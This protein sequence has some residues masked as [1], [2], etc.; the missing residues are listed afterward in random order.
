MAENPTMEVRARLTA[1]SAQFVQGM[2]NATAAA[3][4]FTNTSNMVNSAMRGF[5]VAAAAGM[6]GL[7]ALGTQSFMAAAR[8]Q[9]LDIAIN[10]V[11]KS[12]GLGYDAI[13]NA[14]IGIK[15]MGIEMAVAQR[16]AL[17]FAQ[18]NLKLADA[19]KLARTAQDLAV[20]SGKNSTEE[21]Q[22]LTYAV[23]TQR[24]EL[25]KSAGVNGSV[26]QAYDKM[27]KSLGIS[28][29][30]LTAGQK[31]QAAMN[32][33]LEEGAK[34]AGTYEAAMTSPGKVLRSFARLND[35]LLVAVGNALLKGIGPM[36]VAFYHFEK[37]IV[38]VME[39]TGAFHAIITALTAVMV[40]IFT[41]ITNFIEGLSSIVEK[42]DKAK[43]NVEGLAQKLNQ[44]LPILLAVGAG[45]AAVGGAALFE[46]VPVLGKV[47][48]LVAGGGGLPVALI[49]LAITSQ[50]VRDGFIAI[51]KAL[52]PVVG[53]IKSAGFAMLNVLGYAVGFVGK[54]LQGL[55][56]IINTVVQFFVKHTTIAKILAAAIGAVG[57]AIL[58]TIGYM[59]L[60]KA[61]AAA[62]AVIQGIYTFAMIAFGI[63]ETEAAA[64]S[65]LLTE[66]MQALAVALAETGI[67]EIV[68]S[69]LAFAAA[70]TYLYNT[71]DTARQ[72]IT[73]VF[74]TI[75]NVIGT[76]VSI[77]INAFGQL[78][79][80]IGSII[81]SH[82]TF[83]TIV[84]TVFNFIAKVI[85]GAIN[86]ILLSWA[87]ILKGLATLIHWF[88]QFKEFIGK[89]WS[90]IIEIFEIV[91]NA[92][93]SILSV[94]TNAVGGAT[95]WMRD[96]LAGFIDWMAGVVGKLSKI[97]GFSWIAG[98]MQDAANAVRGTQK[99]VADFN[100]DLKSTKI[101]T[102]AKTSIDAITKLGITLGDATK[103]W[104]NYTTGAEGALSKIANGL[105][106]AGQKV[107]SF[108]ADVDALKV[109]NSIGSGATV[110]GNFLVGIAEGV[111]S[112]TSGNVL[113]NMID[114]VGNLVSSLKETVGF[115][116]IL[117][118][119][120][121]KFKGNPAVDAV[122]GGAKTGDS[123]AKQITNQTDKMQAIRDAMKNG[124]DSIQK[125]LDDLNQA[126]KDFANSLKDTIV[127]FAGLKGVELPD[128]FIPQAQSLI[129]NMQ[130]KLNKA[131]QFSSQ[132]AQLQALN[133]DA[134]A[135]KDIIEAGPVKGA[136]I[137]A[138]IL[139]G[140]QEAVNQVSSLQK[141]IEFA[142]AAIGQQGASAAY[143]PLIAN[144]QS[145]LASITNSQLGISASG[146]NVNVQQGAFVINVNTSKATTTDEGTKMI[147]DA[148]ANVFATLGKELAAK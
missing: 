140:G 24:S 128:G 48:S 78:L 42:M 64:S 117:S 145:K 60:Q 5:S 41:P 56:V 129:E 72:I 119:L 85:G 103:T 134:G 114:G 21:F 27:A 102:D 10:A 4:Q 99:A 139:S 92:I 132:I 35:D 148:I 89:L 115:G 2:N 98:A 96:K 77:V 123:I 105:V 63:A 8:V 142:G 116:D 68:L 33:A 43:I 135:L 30:Q 53:V 16:S 1:D 124:I 80:A 136:Q 121:E 38:K 126:A 79:L 143:D 3:N 54:M 101:V 110:A 14:A 44:V 25:F 93:G 120:Q 81:D 22:L 131:T 118:S 51:G 70:I 122:T 137:A 147:E 144:A 112:M 13:N 34:V 87:N 86:I 52:M 84:A 146:T 45:F 73:V 12:T 61:I 95:Q 37:S 31:V 75:A 108:A 82:K 69:V 91:K 17:M 138:S 6:T 106:D 58:A 133:L 32:M 36:I 29:K 141:A 125:V 19:S 107:V 111:K 49:V 100:P 18:N 109:I 46:M 94:M 88:G 97:P 62:S 65:V 67:P 90:K 40:H 23:M 59:K 104:G 130:M 113:G 74:N 127:G 9:E 26:Q 57:V 15:E 39:G 50:K 55:A 20:L 76:V 11:G 71:N 83:A 28:T 47:L 7:I 66:G